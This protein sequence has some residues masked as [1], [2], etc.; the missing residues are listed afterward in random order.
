M[1]LWYST[2][3]T[4]ASLDKLGCTESFLGLV[5]Q[6]TET[7]VKQDF[8]IKRFVIGLSSVVQRDPNEL[9]PQVQQHIG[10]IMKVIVFLC[11]KSIVVRAK[12]QEKAE[13]AEEDNIEGKGEIYEDE[14][15]PIELISD[16]EDDE[17]DEDYDCNE[18]LDRDL[19]DSKLDSLDEVLFCRDI[20][21]AMQQQSP[22]LYQIY[23]LQCLDQNDQANFHQAIQKAME[24]QQYI[25]QQQQ[26]QQI[27]Q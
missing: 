24:Y 26:Q 23:F 21:Q 16:D 9:P 13:Q 1:C 6:L 18:D 11:Q 4:L 14:E 12:N 25:Q 19:Y 7:T 20:F 5:F 27:M 17:E 8:E 3:H 2:P 10:N 22:Q 15:N